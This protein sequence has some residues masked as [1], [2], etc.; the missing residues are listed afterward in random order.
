VLLEN[1]HPASPFNYQ[2][3]T[4]SLNRTTLAQLHPSIINSPLLH[5]TANMKTAFAVVTLIA[6]ANAQ[7]WNITS[8]PFQLVVRSENGTI[9]DTLSTCHTGAAIESLCLSNGISTSKPNPLPAS[10]FGFNTS[11]YAQPPINHTDLGTPGIL[12]WDLPVSNL[13]PVPSSVRFSYDPSTNTALPLLEP[14]STNPQQLAFNSQDELII[15]SYVDWTANPPASI[16]TYGL[17]R[18]FACKTYY[19]GYQYENLVWGL[20]AEIPQNPTCIPVV[21]RR[22]L[23]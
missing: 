20:G 16:E 4:Q 19:T 9:N 13:G 1:T 22:V 14:G 17:R 3:V 12:T 6:A 21:V 7:Y 23:V 2:T 10:T 11:S 15:Q 8:P 5:A 18:W